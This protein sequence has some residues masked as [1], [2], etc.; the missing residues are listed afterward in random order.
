MCGFPLW[1]FLLCI[2]PFA[3]GARCAAGLCKTLCKG[4]QLP[5]KRFLCVVFVAALLVLCAACSRQAL[6]SVAEPT[7]APTASSSRNLSPETVRSEPV[8]VDETYANSDNV[9]PATQ[10][11]VAAQSPIDTPDTGDFP[12]LYCIGALGLVLICAAGLLLLRRI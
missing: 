4:G 2:I 8:T 7:A 6:S 3:R 10:T 1:G 11:P 12:V 9:S 5:L